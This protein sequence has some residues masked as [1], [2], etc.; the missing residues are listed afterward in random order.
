M[1]R[2]FLCFSVTLCNVRRFPHSSSR[3]LVYSLR[4]C[5]I[6]NGL[7]G[8]ELKNFP[9]WLKEE[10]GGTKFRF[11]LDIRGEKTSVV[12]QVTEKKVWYFSSEPRCKVSNLHELGS[13]WLAAIDDVTR[14]GDR[15]RRILLM[16]L[17]VS[18]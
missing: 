8:V 4:R 14:E 7:F 11:C 2:L 3:K 13:R 17:A 1:T 9:S 12:T 18:F 6:F 15:I 5:S 10:L 16:E